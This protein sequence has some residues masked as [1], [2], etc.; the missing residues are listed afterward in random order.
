MKELEIAGAVPAAAGPRDLLHRHVRRLPRPIRFLGVGSIGLLIDLAI[1]T[2]AIGAGLHPLLGRV[3]SMMLA[4]LVTWRLNRVLTFEPSGRHQSEEAARY[5]F[6][7]AI[8]AATNYAVFAALVV[9]ALRSWPQAAVLA[10]SAAAA[11][12]SYNGHRIFSFARCR[13]ALVCEAVNHS[14]KASRR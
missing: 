2:L 6:V 11:L 1:F 8:A 4:T 7:T 12:V 5:A 3:G 10:G 9:G 14:Q 13:A